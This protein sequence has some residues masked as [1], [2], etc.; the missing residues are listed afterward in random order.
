MAM[1]LAN[2]MQMISRIVCLEVGRGMPHTKNADAA[3]GRANTLWASLIS[4]AKC[5]KDFPRV[6]DS[7]TAKDRR[8]DKPIEIRSY[9][10]LT[11]LPGGHP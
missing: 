1:V 5:T 4:A 11:P 2:T 10:E 6:L 7:D 8:L 3:N 9:D